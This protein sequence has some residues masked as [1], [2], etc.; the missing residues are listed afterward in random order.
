M[1]NELETALSACRA[2]FAEVPEATHAWCCH[3]EVLSER[4][5]EKP[6]V[7]IQFIL[8]HKAPEEQVTRLNNFRPVR[9]M[10]T[11]KPLHDD[12]WAKCKPLYDD[13]VA[14]C[15]PLYDDYDTKRKA[16]YDDYWAKRKA[17]YADYD[18]KRKALDD[19]YLAKCEALDDDYDTKRKAL[20]D[21]YL[22][23]LDALD[24]DC[25]ALYDQE[26]PLGTWNGKSIFGN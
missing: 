2:A 24:D 19:D 23:K 13:Y 22:A 20:D 1:S 9:D 25:V 3:H 10:A 14:K 18:T 4:L 11:F 6:E 21:D 12:Y 17:L 5:T 15:K 8:R 26:V 7:R 16:L